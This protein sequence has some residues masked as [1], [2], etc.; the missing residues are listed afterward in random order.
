MI[1]HQQTLVDLDLQ[2]TTVF[3]PMIQFLNLLLFQSESVS[4]IQRTSLHII[5]LF[6]SLGII[7]IHFWFY[8][9]ESLLQVVNASTLYY[10]IVKLTYDDSRSKVDDQAQASNVAHISRA[11]DPIDDKLISYDIYHPEIH[12]YGSVYSDFWELVKQ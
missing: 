7:I 8:I 10:D 4:T 1:S 5:S 9:I 6:I 11:N 3:E 2:E 12:I